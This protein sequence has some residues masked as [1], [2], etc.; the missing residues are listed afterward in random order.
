MK[1]TPR[2]EPDSSPVSEERPAAAGRAGAAFPS[3]R[4][5]SGLLLVICLGAS[6]LSLRSLFQWALYRPLDMDELEFFRATRWVA[7]GKVPYVDFWEHHFPLLW[8]LMAPLAHLAKEASVESFRV[9]RLGNGLFLIGSAVLVVRLA[10]LGGRRCLPGLTA[11]LLLVSAE[12]FAPF[13]TTY[14]IDGPMC[15][16]FLLGLVLLERSLEASEKDRFLA[17]SA[18][19]A[20]AFSGFCSQRAL[21]GVAVAALLYLLVQ[22]GERWGFRPKVL[23]TVGSGLFIAAVVASSW[24]AGSGLGIFWNHNVVTNRLYER[25]PAGYDLLSFWR[26][27]G[28][29]FAHSSGYR[30]LGVLAIGGL[31]LAAWRPLMPTFGLR[32][33]LLLGG[34]IAFL[35]SIS[36]PYGYQLQLSWW[37]LALLASVSI[38]AFLDFR[39]WPGWVGAA[40]MVTVLAAGSAWIAWGTGVLPNFRAIQAHQDHVLRTLEKVTGREERVL[41]GCGWGVNRESAFVFWFLPRL[42]RVLTAHRAIVPLTEE[43]LRE[44][45]PAAIVM[46]SRTVL[47]LKQVGLE[48]FISANYLPLERAIWVPGMSARAGPGEAKTWTVIVGGRYRLVESVRHARHP[49]FVRPFEFP[50]N[51]VGP[52]DRFVIDLRVEQRAPPGGHRVIWE[53]NGVRLDGSVTGQ[54]VELGRGSRLSAR[55]EGE[56]AEG[57]LAVPERWDRVLTMPCFP[58]WFEPSEEN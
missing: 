53:V 31:V 32:M 8:Y 5:S 11:V 33:A 25:L 17:V 54:P 50:R 51:T 1:E 44:N 30:V 13:V 19:A 18:G 10:S 58:S 43:V 20:L 34:Q 42:V 24:A 49:W 52:A 29:F 22:P 2:G 21:P 41:D 48:P 57:I 47:Y 23:W 45:P 55:N 6:F 12:H 37:L 4:F 26:V 46:D 3:D 14:R 39:A 16:F 27:F 40:T 36:S 28:S 15:F 35:A 56:E 7:E 38:G 9:M